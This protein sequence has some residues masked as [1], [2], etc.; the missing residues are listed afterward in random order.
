[1]IIITDQRFRRSVGDEADSYK[2][3]TGRRYEGG[4]MG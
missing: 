1:M 4:E 3:G 2:V